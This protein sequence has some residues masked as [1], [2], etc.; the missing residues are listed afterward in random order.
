MLILIYPLTSFTGSS[1]LCYG[2]RMELVFSALCMLLDHRPSH[3]IFL[4]LL[5]QQEDQTQ[6]R[7]QAIQASLLPHHFHS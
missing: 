5:T 3:F 6:E 4:S 2:P 7:H 1:D